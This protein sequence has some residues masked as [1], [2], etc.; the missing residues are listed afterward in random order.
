[1]AT[2]YNLKFLYDFRYDIFSSFATCIMASLQNRIHSTSTKNVFLTRTSLIPLICKFF[3][4]I[5]KRLVS[6]WKPIM[7]ETNLL[8]APIVRFVSSFQVD[9]LLHLTILHHSLTLSVVTRLFPMHHFSRPWKHQETLRLSD[10][11]TG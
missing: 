1:M 4:Q 11:F 5:F 7:P 8:I 2:L 10:V 9:T 3:K 6:I